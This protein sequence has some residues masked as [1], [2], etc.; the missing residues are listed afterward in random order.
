MYKPF[1]R[2]FAS[3]GLFLVALSA[4]GQPYSL[5]DLGNLGRSNQTIAEGLNAH[6]QAV[7]FSEVADGSSHAFLYSNGSMQDLGTLG[8]A[9]VRQTPSTRRAR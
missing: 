5:T 6:G 1:V 2:S 8:G 3:A 9:S 4:H 7:G